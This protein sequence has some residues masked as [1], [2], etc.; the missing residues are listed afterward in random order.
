MNN[1]FSV[2]LHREIATY[3]NHMLQIYEYHRKRAYVD[4]MFE[5]HVLHMVPIC[6]WYENLTYDCHMVAIHMIH[7]CFSKSYVNHVHQPYQFHMFV[8]IWLSYV[9]LQKDGT[10]VKMG[11]LFKNDIHQVALVLHLYDFLHWIIEKIIFPVY[12]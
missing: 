8:N 6:I 1:S 7:I 12:S 9:H 10:P 3:A 2:W 11:L 5:I 4:D